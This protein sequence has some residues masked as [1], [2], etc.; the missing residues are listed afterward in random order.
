[1]DLETGL[2]CLKA[3]YLQSVAEAE[4]NV[5]RPELRHPVGLSRC[6]S[7]ISRLQSAAL[8]AYKPARRKTSKHY[9]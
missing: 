4:E 7:Y 6:K 1:M 3:L 5:E 2:G 8:S 9:L